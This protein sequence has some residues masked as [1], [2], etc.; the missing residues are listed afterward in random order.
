MKIVQK[1]EFCVLFIQEE[2]SADPKHWDRDEDSIRNEVTV[3]SEDEILPRGPRE[4]RLCDWAPLEGPETALATEQTLQ[5][6]R[7]RTLRRGDHAG[8]AA[9]AQTEVHLPVLWKWRDLKPENI[10]ID[11]NGHIKLT[12]FGISKQLDSNMLTFNGTKDYCAPELLLAQK[13]GF[14][15]DWWAL[16]LVFFN[17]HHNLWAAHRFEPLLKRRLVLRSRR[18]YIYLYFM[19][20]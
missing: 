2:D 19:S 5:R 12:D 20:K 4:V 17:R 8:L 7:D 18:C 14:M 16:G 9:S 3:H 13:F 6:V 10:L 1:N 11:F 15:V